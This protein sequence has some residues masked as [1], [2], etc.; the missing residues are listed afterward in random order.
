MK[1]IIIAISLFTTISLSAQDNFFLASGEVTWEKVY[2]SEKTKE[3]IIAHFEKSGLFKPFLVEDGKVIATLKPQAID[4][5]RTGIAGVPPI[6]RKTDFAGTI[7]I[8]FKDGK[9]RVTYTQIKL[10]GHG[11]LI[12]KGERQAFELHYVNKDGKDYRKYFLKK[13]RTIYNN[14]FNELFELEK[15]KKEDW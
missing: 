6:L 4:V 12:K 11:D 3:A 2:E 14:H 5:D 10:V 7:M 1:Y 13:P 9:Y 15:E 8:R